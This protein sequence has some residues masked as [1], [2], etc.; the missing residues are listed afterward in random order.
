MEGIPPPDVANYKRKKEQELGLAPGTFGSTP[1]H[2]Q[3][4]EWLDY[5][6]ILGNPQW[7]GPY[8]I[9]RGQRL[10]APSDLWN[11]WENTLVGMGSDDRRSLEPRCP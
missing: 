5:S 9:P 11:M 3:V 7:F 1:G 10:F 6:A 2:A 4:K 8:G